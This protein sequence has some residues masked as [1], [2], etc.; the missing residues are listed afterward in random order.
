MLF[1]NAMSLALAACGV[2]ADVVTPGN[3][4][5]SS[6][7]LAVPAKATNVVY[8]NPPDPNNATAIKQFFLASLMD[9]TGSYISGTKVVSGIYKIKATFCQP[10]K[11]TPARGALQLLVHGMSYNKDTWS[12]LGISTTYSWQDAAARAGYHTLAIDRLGHGENPALDP[13]SVVQGPLQVEIIHNIIGLVRQAQIQELQGIGRVIFVGHSY[14]SFLGNHLAHA[15][16][17]SAAD[18]YVLTGF[19]S[20]MTFPLALIGNLGSAAVVNPGRFTGVPMGYATVE[21]E[22]VRTKTFYTGD[23]DA[24]VAARDFATEDTI[25]IGEGLS[26]GMTPVVAG[27]ATAPVMIVTGDEDVEMCAG[28]PEECKA[29]LEATG[30]LFP[31][32]REFAVFAVEKTGHSLMFH[33]SAPRIFSRVNAWLGH[34]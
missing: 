27:A 28:P 7:Q 29:T 32:A 1:S 33:R 20:N 26:P 16:P 3:P 25:T 19:S 9:P 18:A 24:A 13:F 34:L 10:P 23:Y 22:A 2:T 4:L 17:S 14:G 31:S 30:Q 21:H 15:Y 12:G 11:N 8:A 5:C 6:L